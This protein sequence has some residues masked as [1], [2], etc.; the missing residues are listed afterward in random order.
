MASQIWEVVYFAS[1]SHLLCSPACYNSVKNVPIY[2][3]VQ[4]YPDGLVPSFRPVVA[5][6]YER[7]TKVSLKIL[8]AMGCALKTEVRQTHM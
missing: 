3:H 7:C 2:T 1:Y 6:L 8:E 4:K 5:E